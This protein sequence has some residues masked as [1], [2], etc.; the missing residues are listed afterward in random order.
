MGF[1][2]A[3]HAIPQ[4]LIDLL[5]EDLV[6]RVAEFGAGRPEGVDQALAILKNL[7][8]MPDGAEL[9]IEWFSENPPAA[10]S[11]S[12]DQQ[13]LCL[14]VSDEDGSQEVY[15]CDAGWD[16]EIDSDLGAWMQ[17]YQTLHAPEVSILCW[18]P[19]LGSGIPTTDVESEVL[20]ETDMP[21]FRSCVTLGFRPNGDLRMH[22][23][24]TGEAPTTAFGGDYDRWVDIAPDAKDALL[25]AF[26]RN[27][28]RGD[29][30]AVSRFRDV[31][32]STMYPTTM[33]FTN[34][35]Q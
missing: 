20:A 34:L 28:F 12:L 3:E 35:P 7:P 24:D 32:E 14:S 2:V 26:I 9:Q 18:M 17:F 22:V 21:R 15:R 23:Y 6:S 33:A 27:M 29:I 1:P 31:A 10:A 13:C 5:V 25:L 30:N 4:E 19:K 16:P 11:L 8:E